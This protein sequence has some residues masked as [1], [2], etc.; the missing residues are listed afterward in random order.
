MKV[1]P[2]VPVGLRCSTWC[3]LP[4]AEPSCPFHRP[5]RSVSVAARPA[6]WPAPH[7]RGRFT[8]RP[9]RSPLQP[10]VGD[11]VGDAGTGFHRPSRSVSVAAWSRRMVPLR[12]PR[13][14]RPSRSVS[15][16]AS[17][18]SATCDRAL[19][20]SPAV[21]VGLRCSSSATRALR[22][23]RSAFHRPSRSVSVAAPRSARRPTGRP[24]SFTGRPGRSPLQLFLAGE[25]RHVVRRV[26]PA[27]PVG[28]RCSS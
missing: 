7:R 9:G 23:L 16:A 19:C 22:T 13:F 28:L 17:K 11:Q 18:V 24:A 3:L 26:S 6:W 14:H 27:V 15:V 8:G 1:S 5:S 25:Q 2:A 10:H 21:P 4:A 20:V 12:T